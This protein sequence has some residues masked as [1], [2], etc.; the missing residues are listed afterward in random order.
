MTCRLAQGYE[1]A[2]D[3]SPEEASRKLSAVHG[4]VDVFFRDPDP[5]AVLEISPPRMGLFRAAFVRLKSLSRWAGGPASNPTPGQSDKEAQRLR[6]QVAQLQQQVCL[7]VS[8]TWLAAL[9]ASG[10]QDCVADSRHAVLRLLARV[11]ELH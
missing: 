7:L 4:A 8:L 5:S 10:R 6:A 1:E 9:L 2:E 3:E 11:F